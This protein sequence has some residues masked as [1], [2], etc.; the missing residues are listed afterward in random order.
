MNNSLVMSVFFV[1]FDSSNKMLELTPEEKRFINVLSRSTRSE[2]VIKW[3]YSQ[4]RTFKQEF[5][6]G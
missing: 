1:G 5:A 6:F 4:L 3:Y 2:K